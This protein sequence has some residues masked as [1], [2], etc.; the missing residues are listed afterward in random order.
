MPSAATRSTLGDRHASPPSKRTA[1]APCSAAAE[2]W[3][4]NAAERV[5]GEVVQEPLL[6]GTSEAESF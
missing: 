2:S 3:V 1:A 5:G 6:G 4:L